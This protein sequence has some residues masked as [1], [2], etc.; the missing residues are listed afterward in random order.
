MADRNFTRS[1]IISLI[2]IPVVAAAG[3]FLN[4]YFFEY[5]ESERVKSIQTLVFKAVDQAK[6]DIKKLSEVV[7]IQ[8][9]VKYFD[10]PTNSSFPTFVFKNDSLLF[11]SHIDVDPSSENLQFVDDS[12]LLTLKPGDF[13]A[14]QRYEK[15]TDGL[16]YRFLVLIPVYYRYSTPN[17]YLRPG[18]NKELFGTNNFEPSEIL[19]GTGKNIYSKNGTFLFSVQH[20]GKGREGEGKEP[21][22]YFFIFLGL[23]LI[24]V[25]VRFLIIKHSKS[26]WFLF[27]TTPVLL[28]LIRVLML[29]YHIPFSLVDTDLFNPRFYASSDISPSLG[30]LLLNVLCV[31]IVTWIVAATPFRLFIY[32]QVGRLKKTFKITLSVLSVFLSCLMLIYMSDIFQNLFFNARRSLDITKSID[33]DGVRVASLI[34]VF[35]LCFI[36][37]LSNHFLSRLFIRLNENIAR[38]SWMYFS[39]G[40]LL[41]FI[42]LWISGHREIILLPIGVLYFVSIIYFRISEGFYKLSYRTFLYFFTCAVVCAFVLAHATYDYNL[43]AEVNSKQRIAANLVS[44]NDVLAENLLHETSRK[45]QKEFKIDPFLSDKN[46]YAKLYDTLF[47]KYPGDYLKKYAIRFFLFDKLG[48]NLLPDSESTY[49]L[50]YKD[51]T[52]RYAVQKF[53]TDYP[54]IFFVNSGEQKERGTYFNFIPLSEGENEKGYLVVQLSLNGGTSESGYPG[55]F[56]NDDKEELTQKSDRIAY[57]FYENEKLIYSVGNYNYK[58]NFSKKN[59]KNPN[60]SENGI[61]RN[62][63]H[64]LGVDQGEGYVVVVSSP[65]T[66]SLFIDSLSNF[67]FYFILIVVVTLLLTAIFLVFFRITNIEI[68]FSA[69][70]QIYLNLAFFLPL[71]TTSILILT[72]FSGLYKKEL[73]ETY[74]EKAARAGTGISVALERYLKHG[75]SEEELQKRLSDVIFYTNADINVFAT[76]GKL[77]VSGNPG[78][79]DKGLRAKLI[80]PEAYRQ[81]QQKGEQKIILRDKIGEF[82]Y[83]TVYYGIYAPSDGRLLGILSIPFFESKTETDKRIIDTLVVIM[84]VFVIILIIFLGVSYLASKIL[85]GPLQ[86]ITQKIKGTSFMSDTEPIVWTT[87]DEIGLLVSEYNRMLIKLRESRDA[88]SKSEKESAWREMAKQVAHEIKNPLTPMKLKLQHL[89]RTLGDGDTENKRVQAIDSMLEQIETLSDIASSFSSFAAMPIPSKEATNL[90]EVLQSTLRLYEHMENTSIEYREEPGEFWVLGDEKLLG[91]VISN[92]ILNGIQAVP[93]VKKPHIVVRLFQKEERVIIEVRDNGSGIPTAIRE[94]VF[95]PSFSTK[96]TGSGIGLAVVKKA[97]EQMDGR[98]WFETEENIGT[99]FFV[100]LPLMTY[101]VPDA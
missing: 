62:G 20:I 79:F 23:I 38:A 86:L 30:D 47:A 49:S 34:V 59:L 55:F 5:N 41:G 92:L 58:K 87:D 98:V 67:S 93:K 69:K 70:I 71:L 32:E 72:I 43:S 53:K 18:A 19:S 37:F 13:L 15:K 11:W 82:K 76:S 84:N 95:V 1:F 22:Y 75:I 73:N 27:L 50:D 45:I 35:I 33:F 81:I 26:K 90:R 89:R 14:V 4:A 60:L 64:H 74:S 46:S 96:F 56:L 24:Y 54:E 97:I 77:L 31:L 44:S 65:V 40:V 16:V 36:Y 83:S 100:E 51:L 42:V 12:K 61:R 3:F 39:G 99:S 21:I 85:T 9:K 10:F 78:V 29:R 52:D 2:L 80:H 94:K 6:E 101:V 63:Y 68:N 28:L 25:S 7:S 57:A 8:K 88:L 48:K 91:R 17:K 66:S